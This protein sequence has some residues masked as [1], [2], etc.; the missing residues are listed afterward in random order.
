LLTVVTDLLTSTPN[1]AMKKTTDSKKE[2]TKTSDEKKS[3]TKSRS[4]KSKDK[5]THDLNPE[6]LAKTLSTIES[7]IESAVKGSLDSEENCIPLEKETEDLVKTSNKR[8]STNSG[9]YYFVHK[10]EFFF[11]S[12]LTIQNN[13]EF[14]K[15]SPVRDRVRVKNQKKSRYH[16]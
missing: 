8:K 15:E 14:Q 4:S 6:S 1:K 16:R 13:I 12:L 3:S 7:A 10:I 9:K 11:Q 2:A 5:I